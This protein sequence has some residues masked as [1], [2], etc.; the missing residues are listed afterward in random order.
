MLKIINTK[1]LP[2]LLSYTLACQCNACGISTGPALGNNVNS[3]Q[4][5]VSCTTRL[6]NRFEPDAK[7]ALE[8]DFMAQ[9][10]PSSL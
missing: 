8:E 7:A 5:D 1:P 2:V 6:Q 3:R 4:R 9:V 10:F